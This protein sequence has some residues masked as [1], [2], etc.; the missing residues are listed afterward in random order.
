MHELRELFESLLPM[1]PK[2]RRDAL[3]ALPDK[4]LRG[5]VEALLAADGSHTGTRTDRLNQAFGALRDLS[6]GDVDPSRALGQQVGPY[7][8]TQVLGS[9][10]S[11]TVYR[12]E[13]DD[14]GFPGAVAIKLLSRVIRSE[15]E[16]RIVA[17]EQRA[18]ASLDHPNVAR[19]IDG[20]AIDGQPY[21]IM[22]LIEGRTL[23]DHVAAERLNLRARV[24]LFTRIC[25][26]V[27]AAH[28]ALIVHRDIKP[29]NVMVSRDGQPK[30][31]D[32]GIAKLLD[33]EAP[34]T[35]TLAGLTPA[36]AAPE[37][38]HGGPITT[39]TDVY[40][41]GMVLHELLTGERRR[42]NDTT[43]ASELVSRQPGADPS[44]ARFLRGDLDNVLRKAMQ[45]EPAERYASAGEL[46]QDLRAFLEGGAVSAHPPSLAYRVGKFARRNRFAVVLA[47]VALAAVMVSSV[48]ALQQ[49]IVAEQ[50]AERLS[51]ELVRS[52]SILAFL[53][54]LFE[55]VR[56]GQSASEM[57]SVRDLV[58]E[59]A[60]ELDRNQQLDPAARIELLEFFA[61]LHE[62]VGELERASVLAERAVA[63]SAPLAATQA[64][65]AA[66]ALA[67]RGFTSVRRERY[68]EAEADLTLALPLLREHNVR[69]W[70]RLTAL[71][72]MVA[73]DN[74]RGRTDEALKLVYEA[75]E[76]RIATFG[77]DHP[78][79]G[80]GYND[81]A[82]SLE[83][84]ALYEQSIMMYQQAVAIQRARLGPGTL[85]TLIAEA[86]LASTMWRSGQWWSARA[87]FDKAIE[88][89]EAVGGRAQLP[90]LYAIQKRCYLLNWLLDPAATAAC[91]L[92][93]E[94]TA[95]A[96][97]AD[98]ASFGDVQ[99]AEAEGALERGDYA[100]A[101]ALFEESRQRYGDAP[102]NQSRRARLDIAAAELLL[103]RGEW[104][105]A[106]AS[107]EPALAAQRIR[108][109]P[110][111]L[112]LG[113]SRLI[114]ACRIGGDVACVARHQLEL[115]RLRARAWELE[116]P[117]ALFAAIWQARAALGTGEGLSAALDDLS[118]SQAYAAREL[119][120][121]HPRLIEGTL[122]RVALLAQAGR[123][124]EAAA[125]RA[126]VRTMPNHPAL[127][128]LTELPPGTC[129][130]P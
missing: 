116:H 6:A 105:N 45:P 122:L 23:L 25:D 86:G 91:D 119:S 54:L 18:L 94:R 74:I 117:H 37:Q 39:G 109:H 98:S 9:G 85:E 76:E 118:R 50:R 4:A 24:Q 114:A 65:L 35:Q 82:D 77:P 42:G 61:F 123:C 30:L 70:Q 127:A 3:E 8:L 58:I 59:G 115:D 83:A 89:F 73:V 13:R 47:T 56:R 21:L 55:P 16:L 1:S 106:A 28:Q 51:Q 29:A 36:Y 17:R 44:S 126:S 27:Q 78:R 40:S 48:V 93:R 20:G 43:R 79:T 26:G 97:G 87:A 75:L 88:G 69:G 57:P 111:P 63:E 7:R 110:L 80:V 62:N 103:R 90:R 72:A 34:A 108:P 92:A 49:R 129:A 46:A 2:E 60:V 15:I 12:G 41:L 81:V 95:D 68:D 112:Y 31:L 84:S 33:A 104:A 100:A 38:F 128:D 22:E 107:L 5:H 71:Q 14:G 11:G 130:M 53:S 102:S 113:A 67:I 99:L 64:A 120:P 121:G 66:R 96:L 52:N 19:L 124:D 101:A 32:F 125:A 10:G